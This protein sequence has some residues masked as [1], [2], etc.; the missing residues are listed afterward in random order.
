MLFLKK[1]QTIILRVI[2]VILLF[3]A[4]TTHYLPVPKM[5]ENEK[6]AMRV[7]RMEAKIAKKVVSTQTAHQS[8]MNK[9]KKYQ[10]KQREYFTFLFIILGLLFFFSSFIKKKN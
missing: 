8:Y 6:A 4:F 5:S 3:V 7:A 10:A 2:G 1:Y 9:Y